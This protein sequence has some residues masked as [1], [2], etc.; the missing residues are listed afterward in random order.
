MEDRLYV[1][2]GSF[3]SGKRLTGV[4]GRESKNVGGRQR[5]EGRNL[6]PLFLL[7]SNSSTFCKSSFFLSFLNFLKFWFF[8]GGGG[9]GEKADREKL[10]TLVSFLVSFLL[11][12]KAGWKGAK[13][14]SRLWG[15]IK[16]NLATAKAPFL[17][18]SERFVE[19]VWGPV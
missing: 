18:L 2:R 15:V 8:L 16:Y 1:R 9:G 19:W 6:V 7:R 3:P 11:A 4:S 13:P 14:D 12:R 10:V 5:A 17:G